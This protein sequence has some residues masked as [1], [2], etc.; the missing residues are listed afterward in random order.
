MASR[1]LVINRRKVNLPL[2]NAEAIR[3]LLTHSYP[4][5]VSATY[6]GF[7]QAFEGLTNRILSI[8]NN[9]DAVCQIRIYG[10]WYDPSKGIE[11]ASQL[12]VVVYD[13]GNTSAWQYPIM[14]NYIGLYLTIVGLTLPTAGTFTATLSGDMA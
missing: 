1:T 5:D 8:Q 7:I 2:A 12:I 13:P 11:R 10:T 9:L 4:E 14:D 6:S 3:D